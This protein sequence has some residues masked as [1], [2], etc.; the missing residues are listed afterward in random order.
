[1]KVGLICAASEAYRSI[2][3]YFTPILMVW[4]PAHWM[5]S[6]VRLSSIDQPFWPFTCESSAEA[7]PI[8]TTVRSSVP[9]GAV[10]T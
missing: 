9:S 5:P 3:L 6:R 7:P 10:Y 8:F 2:A 4:S 1:M